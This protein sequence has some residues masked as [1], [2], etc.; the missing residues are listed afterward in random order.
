MAWRGTES[1]SDSEEEDSEDELEAQLRAAA[2]AR[3][4]E[5]EEL[6]RRAETIFRNQVVKRAIV[7][8]IWSCLQIACCML[9]TG[10]SEC[11]VP[12]RSN[13]CCGSPQSECGLRWN[14]R[15]Y[16]RS[17]PTLVTC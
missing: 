15:Y 17:F 5:L 9:G 14:K 12:S 8:R 4:K 7:V 13:A 3:D 11:L 16:T 6:A 1:A 2:E 10:S